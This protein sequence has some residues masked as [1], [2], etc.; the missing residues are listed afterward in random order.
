VS[1]GVR[2]RETCAGVLNRAV[3]A[4]GIGAGFYDEVMAEVIG[5]GNPSAG[6][7][8]SREG[9]TCVLLTVATEDRV[10]WL[11]N[12]IAQKHLATVW[13]KAE[14]WLVGDYLLMPDHLHCFCFPGDREVG[15]ERWISF[16]KDQFRKSH[17]NGD[18]RWQSRGWHHRLR[19]GES[20]A[21]KWDYVQMNPVRKGL[22][23]A[24]EKWRFKGKVQ[25]VVYREG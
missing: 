18:W 1:R 7:R 21:A 3:W 20:Y 13:M 16:W 9:S 23:D 8:V 15:I 2:G 10:P 5:R 24:P 19:N 6:V 22:V 4:R 17:G 11:A 14:G 25:E 12:D